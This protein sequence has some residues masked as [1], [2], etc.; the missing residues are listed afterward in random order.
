MTKYKCGHK[1]DGVIIL[2][3]NL[4][5][6]VAYVEWADSVGVNGTKEQC[7]DCF[8]DEVNSKRKKK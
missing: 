4:L 1:T 7:F 5:S 2:N 8:T 6:M 3:D